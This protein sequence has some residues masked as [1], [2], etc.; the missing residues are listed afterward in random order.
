MDTRLTDYLQKR[1]CST[2]WQPF[3]SALAEEFS[4]QLPE[5]DLRTL[6]QRIGAVFAAAHPLSAC[7]TLQE[8]EQALNQYWSSQDWGWVELQEEADHLSLRHHLSPLHAAFG[9]SAAAWSPAFLESAYQTWLRQ[10]GMGDKL[11]IKQASALDSLGSVAFRLS[12]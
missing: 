5:A 3:L 10:L 11:T 8:L 2:Q 6:M 1:Q 7:A 9:E 4:A 12:V